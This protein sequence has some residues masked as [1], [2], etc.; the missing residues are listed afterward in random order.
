MQKSEGEQQRKNQEDTIQWTPEDGDRPHHDST[1][2]QLGKQLTVQLYKVTSTFPEH[3]KF[4]LTAQIRRGAVS[5]PSN[6]AEGKA[7]R[8]DADLLRF[9]YMARGSLEEIDTQMELADNLGYLRGVNSTRAERTFENLS[10]AL[11]SF[12]ATVKSDL[13]ESAT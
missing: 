9:L 7:R 6:I 1:V 10:R 5:V 2:W 3:E 8:T 11:E 13:K 12:I 4:G